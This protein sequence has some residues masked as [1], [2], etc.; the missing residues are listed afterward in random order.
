MDD[1]TIV[2]GDAGGPRP[3]LKA[4][5][6]LPDVSRGLVHDQKSG[7]KAVID[8]ELIKNVCKVRLYGFLTDENFFS[9]FFVR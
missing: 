8:L 6:L 7:L 2:V 9:Y 1:Q 3:T 5:F 4:D